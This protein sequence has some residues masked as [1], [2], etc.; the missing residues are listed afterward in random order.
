MKIIEDI[1]NNAKKIKGKIILPEANIDERVYSA[2]KIIL[3][4]KLAEIVVFGKS[5]DF[6]S[7]FKSPACTII[8]INNFKELDKYATTLY[9]MRKHKGMTIDEAKDLVKNPAYFACMMLYF[10]KADGMVAGANWTTAN[11]LRPALQTIKTKPGKSIVTGAMLMVKEDC[12]PLLFADISLCVNPTSEELAQIAI[13]NAE[14]YS[15][16]VGQTPYV[17]LL[18]YSTNGSAES[19]LVSK[20]QKAREIA[21][22]SEYN[23]DGEMQ[24]DAA[25]DQSVAKKKFKN[26]KVAGK[27]NVLIFPD[28]D[29]GNIGYKL[30]ARLGGYTAIGPIMLNFNKPINDL[31][32]GCTTDEIVLTACITKLQ[33]EK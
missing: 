19:E 31:S 24:A 5:E 25:L 3:K 10:N 33:I 11:T 1:K 14:F 8:D 21:V 32:R 13:S 18:S 2:C 17:A 4:Q 28:L 23:I 15:S 6:D 22:K 29:A 27:A 9:E 26:S 7:D 30:V 12:A 16:I 20:V